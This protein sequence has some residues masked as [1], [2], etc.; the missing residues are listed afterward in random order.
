MDTVQAFYAAATD[1]AR[2]GS[3]TVTRRT[4]SDMRLNPHLHA[5]V[6]DGAFVEREGQIVFEAR[7]HLRTAD[8]G[9]V[10][11]TTVRCIVRHLR[12]LGLLEVDEAE[13]GVDDPE[14]GLAASAVSGL[15]PPPAGSGSAAAPARAAAPSPTTCASLAGFSLHAATR[16]GGWNR[17]GREALLRYVLRPPLPPE[18]LE[19][20]RTAS[21]ASSSRSRIRTGRS[22]WTWIRCPCCVAWR[23]ASRRRGGTRCAT[24]ACWP[25]Q[26][27]A[28]ADRA[29][30]RHAIGRAATGS[31][32][33]HGAGTGRGPSCWRARS[34]WTCCGVRGARDACG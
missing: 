28:A 6:I 2:T 14:G 9:A 17:E 31:R 1:E 18:R 29:T 7:G 15:V 34:G 19:P 26:S 21:C 5:V 27:L 11:E 3:V 13:P 8:V 30:A 12:C 16:A 32:P 23:P 25:G 4:S 24:R 20:G 22:Q 33:G 10:L